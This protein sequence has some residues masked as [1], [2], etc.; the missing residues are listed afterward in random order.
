[1]SD[2]D[3]LPAEPGGLPFWPAWVKFGKGYR[4]MANID[5]EKLIQ[6]LENKWEGRR[7]PLCTGGNWDVSDKLC[8]L[9]E[10]DD[11]GLGIGDIHVVPVVPVVPVTC[12]NCGN[13]ILVSSIVAGLTEKTTGEDNNK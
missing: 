8:E 13:T 7:C 4:R 12:D 11:T 3:C 5:L 9:R 10:V 1:M 2:C 6:H